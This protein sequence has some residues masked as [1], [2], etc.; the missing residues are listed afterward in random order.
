LGGIAKSFEDK[1]TSWPLVGDMIQSART[2]GLQDWNKSIFNEVLAPIGEKL[3]SGVKAGHDAFNHA[4]EKIGAA[5]DK[6]IPQTTT[7]L[8]NDFATHLQQ[9]V[10]PIV[11]TLTKDAQAQFYDILKQH[12]LARFA[13]GP[14]AGDLVKTV[15][16]D[17]GTLAKDFS[18]STTRNER[19]IGQALEAVQSG[20]RDATA[21]QNPLAAPVLRQIDQS[22]AMLAGLRKAA[23][24][25]AADHGVFTG[26]QLQVASAAGDRSVGRNASA[27]G[28][29]KWQQTAQIAQDVLPSKVPDSGTRG[30]E[31]WPRS[32]HCSPGAQR[33]SIR[34]SV[35]PA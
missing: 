8:D 13:N 28:L 11:Q 25:T 19:A 20:L 21:R 10:A 12:V 27:R 16:S 5:Y 15:T 29:A 23:A 3:D 4:Y 18:G 33:I 26:K 14:V 17:L 1:A 34:S 22:Y 32:P 35:W 31:L 24:S 2:R 7:Q 9:S 30:A 6:I